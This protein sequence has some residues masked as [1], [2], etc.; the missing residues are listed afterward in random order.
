MPLCHARHRTIPSFPWQVFASDLAGTASLI[1]DGLSLIG[2]LGAGSPFRWGVRLGPCFFAWAMRAVE[3]PGGGDERRPSHGAEGYDARPMRSLE[4]DRPG[5][6]RA[7][8]RPVAA[9]AAAGVVLLALATAFPAVARE[10][11]DEVVLVNGNLITGEIMGMS[12]GQLDY[13]TDDAGRLTIEWLKIVRVTS[14]HIF[15]VETSAGVKHLSALHP[16][17]GNGGGAVQLDEGT[18]IPI[19]EIVSIVPLDAGLFSRLSAY[20]DLGLALAKANSAL[21]LNADGFVGY[22]GERMGSS[23]QFVLYLQDS[24]NVTTATSGSVQLTG[25]LYFGRWTAQLGVGAE[26]NSE[27]DLKL[28]LTLLGGAAYSAIRNNWMELMANAGLAGIREQYTAGDPSWYLTGYLAGSWNAFRYDSPKLDA[29]ISVAVYP[30]LTDLGRV[31]VQAGMRVKYELFKDFNVGLSLTDTYDSRPPE[32]ASNND[33]NI[34]F[35]IGW[36]YRR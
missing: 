15:E 21:T 20:L 13:K 25:D 30:Y 6:G 10:K 29:G 1:L 16:L 14:V 11:T 19:G 34:S 2:M 32:S 8:K 7:L 33:Y 4:Y 26:E 22:R 27:L 28:R 3:M 31:R 36:S 9:L 17:P 12:R 24:T 18:R 5:S 35:T 23:L